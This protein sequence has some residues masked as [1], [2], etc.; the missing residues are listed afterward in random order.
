MMP[1]TATAGPRPD[2]GR[3]G[4]QGVFRWSP[5]LGRLGQAI[6]KLFQAAFPLVIFTT[7]S[8]AAL[9]PAVPSFITR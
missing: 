8:V 2:W 1:T 4:P 7:E 5:Q 3:T 6:E 9:N